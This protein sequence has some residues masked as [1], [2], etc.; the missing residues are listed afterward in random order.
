MNHTLPQLKLKNNKTE[1]LD[2][3]HPW[4]FSGAILLPLTSDI[5]EGELVEV[6][7]HTGAFV[8]KG[9]YEIG[10]IAVRVLTFEQEEIDEAF[11]YSRLAASYGVRK[12]LGLVSA[13]G[14]YRLVHG[15]GDFLPGLIVDVY[16][17]VVVMQAHTI[18]IHLMRKVIAGQIKKL[19]GDDLKCIY[20]KSDMTLPYKAD[21][22][23]RSGILWGELSE[24]ECREYG[25]RFVPD[26]EKGQ[27]TGFFIDQRENR[28]LLERYAKDRNVLN[29][30]CYT[31]GFSLYA[32]RGGAKRVVSVDSSGKA[33]SLAR[34][35]IELNH[36]NTSEYSHEEIAADAFKYLEEIPHGEFDLI[37]LDPPAFAKHRGVVANALQG[38]RRINTEAIRKI[39]PG[40]IL[41]TFSCSQAVSPLQFRQA[42]F[43]SSLLAQ[44]KVR[45]LHFLSQPGDHPIS[46]YH[47]EG[48]YLKGLVLYVE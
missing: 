7:D 40:G 44:R 47:P 41:F 25:L 4:I 10:S 45:I 22:H 39:A 46:M 36:F 37:V 3:R 42:V 33:I 29:T 35:N 27:K 31:G 9:Y 23:D 17:N 2:R 5:H 24:P 14:T 34:R 11:W 6:L 48:E 1:S 32:L 20:Y 12:A 15:E 30:F 43:T 18:G 19:Y 13:H 26:I 16:G 8:A 28:R 21:A 38:Y